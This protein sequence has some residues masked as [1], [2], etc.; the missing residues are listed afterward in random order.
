MEKK[1][2]TI[3]IEEDLRNLARLENLNVSELINDFLRSYLSTNSTEEIDMK[4]AEYEKK[5][6]VLRKRKHDMI[7]AGISE[8]RKNG[9]NE[10]ILNELRNIFKLRRQQAGKNVSADESWITSPK[11]IQKCKLLGKDCF[12]V[13]A[14]LEEW[15][16]TQKD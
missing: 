15:Y 10:N 5:L 12:L 11:N 1:I 8:E 2:T 7:Q 16:A 6:V 4:I 3:Y 14:E 9:M 13:L